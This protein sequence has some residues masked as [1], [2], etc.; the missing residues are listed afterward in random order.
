[1]QETVN[2]SDNTN[3]AARKL[4]LTT[5]KEKA[6][7]LSEAKEFLTSLREDL[8]GTDVDLS[9]F[10]VENAAKIATNALVSISEQY[11][12]EVSRGAKHFKEQFEVG[13]F[14]ASP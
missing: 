14:L 4:L 13:F 1:M 12:E 11:G 9:Q 5:F 7:G 2:F 8:T 10:S 3:E 6:V